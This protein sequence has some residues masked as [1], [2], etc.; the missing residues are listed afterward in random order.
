MVKIQTQHNTG[1]DAEQ[2][3]CAIM[4]QPFWNTT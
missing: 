4:A 1:K 2:E 3:I